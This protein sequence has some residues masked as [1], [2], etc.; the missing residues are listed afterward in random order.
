MVN[1]LRLYHRF[2]NRTRP[3]YTYKILEGE[4]VKGESFLISTQM[5]SSLSTKR[6][7]SSPS[8]AKSILAGAPDAVEPDAVKVREADVLEFVASKL[9]V[10][11]DDLGSIQASIGR[12]H[13]ASR[14]TT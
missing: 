14:H 13:H 10:E 2:A 6:M 3:L 9:G 12:W 5:I 7:K 8:S 1:A 11:A 4:N